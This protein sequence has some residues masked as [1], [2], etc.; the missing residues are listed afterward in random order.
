M[1]VNR[2]GYYKWVARKGTKN[3]YEQDREVLTEPLS[4]AHSKH[5]SY[6]Y[7]KLAKMVREEHK[8]FPNLVKGKWDADAP[9]KLIASDMAMI[10]HKGVRYEWTY[11]LDTFNNEIISSHISNVVGDGRPYFRIAWIASNNPHPLLNIHLQLVV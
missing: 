9:L 8:K 10:R 11:L 1:N 2:S 6:G 3:R 4:K 7:H 5:R